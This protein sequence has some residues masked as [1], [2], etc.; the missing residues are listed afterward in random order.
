MQSAWG[1]WGVEMRIW[2]GEEKIW[3]PA[4]TF[5]LRGVGRGDVEF[6]M[7]FR[8][9]DWTWRDAVRSGTCLALEIAGSSTRAGP[10][11]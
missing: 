6:E 8:P 10:C 3:N 11:P 1:I 5:L 7:E 9:P 2:A 4:A